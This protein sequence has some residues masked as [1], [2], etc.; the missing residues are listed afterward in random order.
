MHNTFGHT[1]CKVT[2][3]LRRH[4]VPPLYCMVL[5]FLQY[6]HTSL[7]FSSQFV[8]FH[9]SCL[10]VFPK[11]GKVTF[12]TSLI[13]EVLMHLVRELIKHTM[14]VLSQLKIFQLENSG[15]EHLKLKHCLEKWPSGFFFIYLLGFKVFDCYHLRDSYRIWIL[16]ML[17]VQYFILHKGVEGR[18]LGG[19]EK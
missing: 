13:L 12:G 8:S 18:S 2:T 1:F 7:C 15:C 14:F 16:M 3:S 10:F 9:F 17:G 11:L 6:Y 19:Q 4:D 5:Q